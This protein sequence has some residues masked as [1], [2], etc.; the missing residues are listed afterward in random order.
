MKVRKYLSDLVSTSLIL[1][2]WYS[3]LSY[4]KL[5]A[6]CPPQLTGASRPAIFFLQILATTT[7]AF[8]SIHILTGTLWPRSILILY[9]KLQAVCPLS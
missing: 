7:F 2:Y 5:Q 4:S 1:I 6:V 8:P 9:S 3:K